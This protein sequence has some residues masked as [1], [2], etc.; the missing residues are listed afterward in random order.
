M[1]SCCKA[2]V[3]FCSSESSG[4]LHRPQPLPP[5]TMH[6]AALPSS[7]S[8]TTYGLAS[9]R[10]SFSSYS[11]TF[12]GSTASSNHVN[13]VSNGLAPQVRLSPASQTSTSVS[14]KKLNSLNSATSEVIHIMMTYTNMWL[15][16]CLSSHQSGYE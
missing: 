5:S 1:C 9:N 8:G 6:Q 4:T 14:T 12:I 16:S 7:D 11:D 15:G 3:W 2:S 13:P 10:H